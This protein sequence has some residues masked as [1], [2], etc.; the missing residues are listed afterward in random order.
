MNDNEIK[1][2]LENLEVQPSARCWDAIESGIEAAG[3]TAGSTSAAATKAAAQATRHLSAA[4][5]K[6]I[7]AGSAVTIAVGGALVATL[8]LPNA[9]TPSTPAESS[10]TAHTTS[11]PSPSA[12]ETPADT[13][14]YTPVTAET[15]TSSPTVQEQLPE[16][17]IIPAAAESA[18]PSENSATPT[19][20]VT[21][22]APASSTTPQ[23][24]HSTNIQSQPTPTPKASATPASS[25]PVASQPASSQQPVTQTEDPVLS[26]RDDL[27]FT[28]PIAIEIPNIITPNGD[29][30]NDLLVIKGI[31]NCEKS[32]LIIRSKSGAIVLQ[33]NN[34]QNNWDAQNALDGTYFYQFYYTI[35]G[36]EETRTGTLTIIR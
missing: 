22:P 15:R 30:Y 24:S 35:H 26:G 8:L 6:A 4:A 19:L 36:I 32:K 31:E 27:D 11:L 16:K 5:V 33:V 34:Y 25:R 28:P 23:P 2:L 7:I 12:T 1:Q 10:L 3:T 9:N 18:T 29:G 20:A 17:S 13:I 14:A 21:H